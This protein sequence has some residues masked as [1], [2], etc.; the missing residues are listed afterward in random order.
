[1]LAKHGDRRYQSSNHSHWQLRFLERHP[2]GSGFTE[3]DETIPEYEST[4]VEYCHVS[5]H[6][7]D[8]DHQ[9]EYQCCCFRI[10]HGGLVVL[11]VTNTA[12]MIIGMMTMHFQKI[13]WSTL[14]LAMNVTNACFIFFFHAFSDYRVKLFRLQRGDVFYD[15][16]ISVPL[17]PS[18]RLQLHGE[19]FQ[20]G[21]EEV[22][23]GFKGTSNLS[24]VF[25]LYVCIHYALTKTIC[26]YKS[27]L[28]CI[29]SSQVQ[30][31]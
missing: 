28:R 21:I 1:M 9:S 8:L 20:E 10:N 29:F 18:S 3:H 25:I 12:G 11:L 26:V 15:F 31:P 14:T 4:P 16:D 23:N 17:S 19:E 13:A 6:N 30:H 5:T 2:I 27:F 22:I 24:G 7:P